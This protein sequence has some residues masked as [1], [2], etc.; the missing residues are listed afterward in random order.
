MIGIPVKDNSDNP[1]VDERF[2]RAQMFCIVNENGDYKVVNNSAKEQASGAGGAAVSILADEDVDTVISPHIGPKAND[3]IKALKIK[4]YK[5]G[6]AK[7][8]KEALEMLKSGKL[9][10]AD[11][12]PAGLKRV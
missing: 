4:V 1:A 8:V 7:T 6:S 5:V 11:A 3:A 12:E 2:G 10:A 9:E